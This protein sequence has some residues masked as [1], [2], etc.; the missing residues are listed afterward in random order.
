MQ[1]CVYQAAVSIKLVQHYIGTS[2][3]PCCP[4]TSER[5][6]HKKITG[7][8]LCQ[9]TQSSFHRKITIYNVVLICLSQRC[10]RKIPVQC[11]PILHKQ[12]CTKKIYNVFWICLGQ[13]CT[14]KSPMQYWHMAKR[15]L[16]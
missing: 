12:L 8:M 6:L 7:S 13:H 11:W 3:T 15:Q 1:C 9:T 10:T 2:Y 16:L 4:N 5:T 14:T